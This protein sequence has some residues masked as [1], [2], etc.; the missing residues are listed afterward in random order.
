MRTIIHERL[1][2]INKKNPLK[3]LLQPKTYKF[4]LPAAPF[5]VLHLIFYIF[6]TQKQRFYQKNNFYIEDSAITKYKTFAMPDSNFDIY[7]INNNSKYDLVYLHG[8]RIKKDIHC[9][10]ALK[11][12]K[13]TGYNIILPFYRGYCTSHGRLNE[14]TIMTDM[15]LLKNV[16]EKRNTVKYLFG[17]SLGSA[18]AVYLA[19][20]YD[21]PKIILENPFYNAKAVVNDYRFL[22]YL[23]F[24]MCEKW[25]TNERIAKIK[26]SFLILLSSNDTLV[27]NKN[28]L[29]LAGLIEDCT[30]ERLENAT[31]FNANLNPKFYDIIEK[32][33]A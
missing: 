8:S 13:V 33:L 18:V 15:H 16:L 31:H 9:S 7:I 1:P 17:Q 3:K 5:L 4:L 23:S 19:T 6:Y 20:I 14:I 24:L 30:V 12:S 26:S 25:E 32:F 11:L 21:V 27:R 22:R 29:M 10:I 2:T 28:G